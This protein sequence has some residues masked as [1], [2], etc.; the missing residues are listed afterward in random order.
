MSA[1]TTANAT[2]PAPEPHEP[3]PK[4]LATRLERLEALDRVADPVATTV[5]DAIPS[6]A[7]KD[8][9]SGTWLGHAVH[10]LLTDTVIGAW[11]SALMLD[12]LGGKKG[13]AGADRLVAIGILCAL[14]TAA[15]GASDWS[16]CAGKE[17]R[18]GLVHALSNSAAL[19]L[20]SASYAARRRGSRG[21]G[22]ALALA[23]GGALGLGGY[24]GGHLSYVRGVGVNE[25][26]FEEW[27]TD[28][29]AVLDE[30]DVPQDG[31]FAHGDADGV[32][33][34]VS[35]Q[36]GV[37]RAISSRCTHRSGALEDGE[38]DDGCVVCPLHG[39]TFSLADGSVRR[40]P[41]TV[42]QP[43][44]DVR[45]RSGRVEVRAAEREV[46]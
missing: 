34:L 23:G 12:L 16:D 11:T 3:A 5:R 21:L 45:V 42:P 46:A 9:L 10:P 38:V 7:V 4:Q 41:A 25:T 15:T 26:A 33:V 44:F 24:L 36:D 18:V 31:S 27:P 19:G 2:W 40:G 43:E 22:R 28:W 1:D 14:P 8:A 20:F 30:S 35:R 32:G 6:G 13:R 29:V 37:L 17:R 39:S